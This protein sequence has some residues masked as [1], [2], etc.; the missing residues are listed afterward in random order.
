MKRFTLYL[1][2][3]LFALSAIANT[4]GSFDWPQWQG[5]DRN[6]IS[7][8]RGLLQQWP[9]SGPR[10]AWKASGLGGG[11]STPSI[12]AGRVFGMSNRGQ[13]E[14]VWALSETDGRPLWVTRLG[15]ALSQDWEQAKEGPGSTPTVDGERL[16][17]IG[18]AGEVSCVKVS[19]GTLV[20]Q[21]SL[22][23]EFGAPV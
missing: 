21:R 7:K 22:T 12:A 13:D 19:D 6:A 10:L 9:E 4:P 15:P 11:D 16:Y 23:R 14:V 20:W 8:E 17:V 18:M 2:S 5:P 1:G 3:L